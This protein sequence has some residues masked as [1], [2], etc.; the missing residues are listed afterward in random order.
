MI[1]K[2]DNTIIVY[3]AKVKKYYIKYKYKI[4]YI[5]VNYNIKLFKISTRKINIYYKKIISIKK[6]SS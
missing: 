1:F 3:L 2:I 6:I 5:K 4:K